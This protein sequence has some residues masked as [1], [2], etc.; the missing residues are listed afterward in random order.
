MLLTY[1]DY[2]EL[3]WNDSFCTLPV[4]VFMILIFFFCHEYIRT[5]F[6]F[7]KRNCLSW[8]VRLHYHSSIRGLIEVKKILD[9]TKPL[10]LHFFHLICW[11]FMCNVIKLLTFYRISYVFYSVGD[12]NS[13]SHILMSHF[14]FSFVSIFLHIIIR[15][16][17]FF[18]IYP[19]ECDVKGDYCCRSLSNKIECN[20]RTVF[21][22]D[23]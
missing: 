16:G 23:V 18:L 10:S 20:W 17:I 3:Y 9:N 19:Y 14:F 11:V 12:I 2:E 6:N 8:I 4:V 1:C 21:Y 15:Y 13:L 22:L 5:P 7:L